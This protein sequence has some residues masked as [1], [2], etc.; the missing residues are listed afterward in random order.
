MPGGACGTILDADLEF[1]NSDYGLIQAQMD[2]LS[3]PGYCTY[4]LQIGDVT[5]NNGRFAGDRI[6]FENGQDE[7]VFV[8]TTAIE[9]YDESFIGTQ[10]VTLT[11]C[12]CQD[13]NPK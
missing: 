8:H 12:N 13:P 7:P 10:H 5:F 11:A 4:M 1:V 2:P 9:A 6:E 3:I